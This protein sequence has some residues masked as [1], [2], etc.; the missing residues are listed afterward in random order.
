MHPITRVLTFLAL[1]ALSGGGSL[2]ADRPNIL[3]ISTEDISPNLGCYGDTYADTPNLDA[4][5]KKGM[6]FLHAWSNA[7]VCAPARTT[8]IS[9][10]YPPSTGGE[11]MRSSVPL[12]SGCKMFPQ[13]LREA[14][15]YCTNNA[16]E[17]YNL[18]K[19][20]G[21]W[22][23]SSK[24]AHWRKRGAGQPFFAVFNN[25]I[26]HESK[27]RAPGHQL[28]H[29][30]AKAPVPAYQPDTPEVRHDWAQYYDNI[31]TMDGQSARLLQ[32]VADAGLAEDTIVFFWGDHGAGMPR[33]KRWPYNSGLQVP[34]IAYFPPKWQHLAPK[35][36][37]PGA[38]SSELVAFVDLGATMLS[39]AGVKTPSH[40][41]GRAFAGEFRKEAP[42]F[43][44]GFR[45]RMDERY[46]LV[47]SATDGRYVY[48]RQYM[49]HLPY[50]QHINY[51]FQMPTTRVW[52]QLFLDGKLNEVQSRF[53]K[54]K[55][56]EEL[57]DLQNDPWEV[58]NLA[59]SK[60]H[61][62]ILARFREAQTGWCSGMRDLGF[63]PEAERLRVANGASP[64]DA[65]A[66][67]SVYPLAEVMAAANT[68]S[69]LRDTGTAG[70]VKLLAHPNAIVR[71][72][73]ALGLRMRGTGAVEA[74][75]EALTA[76]LE[77]ESPSVRI[78]AAEALGLFGK[79]ADLPKVL[80][81]LIGLS[82]GARHGSMTSVEALNAIDRLGPKASSLK[83]QIA[84]LPKPGRQE[85]QRLREYPSRLVESLTGASQ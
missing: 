48:L 73:G 23:E 85:E 12:P 41:Q 27:I 47:R 53:W 6:I 9:G 54:P 50:G 21:V 30:P 49:P 1:G 62:A 75:H 74:A 26:T 64:R 56:A 80:E 52:N 4:L 66:S 32:Q 77:D 5:A 17:D 3:W 82:D 24:N 81:V 46:D 51:M 67:D 18:Q 13:Y 69:N 65:F 45:G 76:R 39:L 10:M 22:D 35:G 61:A 15:Y 59:D 33:S 84:R 78:V 60:E 55:P 70:L 38:K 29:D 40:M 20:D 36:Y 63:I 7:P 71:Y 42:E 83:D 31:T 2:A 14:G 25:E 11:H 8:I 28:V 44:F 37:Q 43:L 68:A 19:P 57:Y 72:W 34:L 16:K 58:N 79:P